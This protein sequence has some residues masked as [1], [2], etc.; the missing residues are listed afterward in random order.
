M[1]EQS[2][3]LGLAAAIMGE[4]AAAEPEAPA[5][6]VPQKPKRRRKSI[7]DKTPLPGAAVN[8]PAE[9]QPRHRSKKDPALCRTRNVT[10]LMTEQTYRMFK[11]V[12]EE[13]EVSMNGVINRLVRRYIISHDIDGHI[14]DDF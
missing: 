12:T 1:E 7:I 9:K 11:R 3:N 10:V 13:N 6:E 8:P 2:K 14:L 5:A 4:G